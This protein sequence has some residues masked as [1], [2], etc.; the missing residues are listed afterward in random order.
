MLT[1]RSGVA[2]RAGPVGAAV[3]YAAIATMLC[4]PVLSAPT[5]LALGHPGNDVWNHVWGYWWVA[6]SL[7]HG[8][9][10]LHT[11]LLGWPGGGSLWFIDIFNAVLTL[12]VQWIAGPVA[13]YNAGIWFNLALC[14]FGAWALALRA[15]RSTEGALLAGIAYMT[16]PH[17]LAQVYNGISETVAAGWLPLAVLAIRDAAQEPTPRRGAV[18]GLAVAVTAV[19]NWYYGLFAGIVLLGLLAR[20]AY[21]ALRKRRRF[22]VRHLRAPA[23]ALIVGGAI[24]ALVAAVPFGL[25]ALSMS[26]PDALV[27]RDPGFVWM[28]LVMHNMTDVLALVHPGKFY[29]PDLHAAY[30]EDLLVVV[31]LGAALWVPALLPLATPAQREAEPWVLLL[32]AFVLL[33]LGPFLY[34]DGHYVSVAGGWLPLPFLLLFQWFPMFSRISHAYRFAIGCT[35]ALSVLVAFVVRVAP[36]FGIPAAAAALGIGIIRVVEA[37]FFSPAVFPLPVA[38]VTIPAVYAHLDGGA[39]I[40]LPIT[41]PVLARSKLLVN[42][43]VHQQPVPFGLNDPVPRYLHYNHYTHYIVGLER[44]STMFLPP[45]L[46]YIDLAAGKADLLD[47]GARWI[48]V[49]REGYTESQYLRIAHFLDITAKVT[50]DDGSVRVY[51]LRD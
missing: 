41:M 37:L 40:D 43:I 14:G 24:T 8:E 26:A 30:S 10:P 7:E 2:R 11:T 6:W 19:A 42:Q 38:D 32:G 39:V 27:T 28:T 47:R 45:E 1:E 51:D 13:A 17:L 4:A 36:R 23:L 44:R 50:D 48:V 49:H 12:P 3:L 25:F 16:A 20:A 5:R 31:Y 22:R 46:P 34:F 21:C 35:L 9:L 33:A 18:A 15:T 29:S